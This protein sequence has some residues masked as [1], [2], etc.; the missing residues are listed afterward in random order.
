M[1]KRKKIIYTKELKDQV[2][3]VE[4]DMEI[5]NIPKIQTNI[6]FNKDIS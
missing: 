5:R 1:E 6:S 3:E 2:D 4:K